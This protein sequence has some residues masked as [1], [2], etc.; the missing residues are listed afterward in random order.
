MLFYGKPKDYELVQHIATKV[1]VNS[2]MLSTLK[3]Q[4]FILSMNPGE[5]FETS[6]V[7]PLGTLVS[8]FKRQTGQGYSKS[9]RFFGRP[10]MSPF[11]DINFSMV[12]EI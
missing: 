9:G 7:G 3:N 12:V 11:F 4:K 6:V 8:L 2:H 5:N 1:E 10:S